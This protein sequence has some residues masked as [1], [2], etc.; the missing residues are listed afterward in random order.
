MYII[1][2]WETEEDRNM[3]CSIEVDSFKNPDDAINTAE[4][5]YYHNDIAACEVQNK[6]DEYKTVY[7]LSDD[8]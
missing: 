3:G 7:H 6:K 2:I 8:K 1:K 4:K 5:Y